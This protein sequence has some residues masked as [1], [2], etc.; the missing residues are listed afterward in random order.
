MLVEVRHEG[1]ERLLHAFDRDG[2]AGTLCGDVQG[3][4]WRFDRQLG[5]V[6][7]PA[8]VACP[9]CRWAVEELLAQ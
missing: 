1:G 2:M 6:T 3:F 4:D 5:N 8:E 9:T 7:D